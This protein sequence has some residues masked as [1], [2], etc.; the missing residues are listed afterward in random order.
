MIR[1]CCE[2]C[3]HKLSVPDQSSGKRGKCPKCGNIVMIPNK[4]ATIELHCGNCGQKITVSKVH[5]G[6]KGRCPNCKNPIAIPRA[7]EPAYI[8]KKDEPADTTSRLVG[9]DVGLT[10][11]DVPEELKHQNGPGEESGV[12]EEAIEQESKENSQTEEAESA[13]RRNLPWF[14]DIFLYPVSLSGLTQLAIFTIIPTLIAIL[15]MLLGR[16]GRIVVLPGLIFNV[17]IFLYMGW[18]FTECVRDSA[19]GGTRA[20]EAFAFMGAGEMWSQMQHIIGCYLILISPSFFYNYFTGELDAVYWTLLIVGSFFFPMGLLACIMF[21]SIRGLNPI[22]LLGSI[23]HTFFQYCGLV[24]LVIAIV[25]IFTRLA[26]M[27][28]PEVTKQ[29]PVARLIFGGV[30]FFIGLYV[31][32]VIAHIIGRFYRRYED[33]LN[34]EV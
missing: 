30:L 12:I 5:A 14:I 13:G 16:A 18:Y 7:K 17:F 3:G 24:L 27:A 28:G 31:A 20:P 29:L 10:L 33:K 22:L 32:F 23:F 34:W 15:R 11:L 26:E 9:N 25:F 1:F 4:T 21:D 8:Q 2:Q 19:K 6:K